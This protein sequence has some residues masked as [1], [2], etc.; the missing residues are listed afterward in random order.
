MIIYSCGTL[1]SLFP[2]IHILIDMFIVHCTVYSNC[3]FKLC[4]SKWYLSKKTLFSFCIRSFYFCQRNAIITWKVS[5]IIGGFQISCGNHLRRAHW[6]QLFICFALNCDTKWSE[7]WLGI[8]LRLS[9]YCAKTH[10]GPLSNLA[11][12]LYATRLVIVLNGASNSRS[13][14]NCNTLFC[15]GP[16]QI[17]FVSAI[18]F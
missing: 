4:T 8:G 7:S 12:D 13:S 11:L 1:F 6:E 16:Q 5:C 10:H 15:S 18:N 9:T 14:H 3:L 17:A 2:L